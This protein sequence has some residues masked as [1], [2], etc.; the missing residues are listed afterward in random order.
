MRVEAG[1]RDTLKDFLAD[2]GIQTSI[3]YPTA[4]YLL[5]PYAE[6]WGHQAG[7]FS[8]ADQL[9]REILSLPNHPSLTEEMLSYVA[10]AVVNFFDTA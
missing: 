7:E 10:Q 5:P 4:L 8:H 9:T 2:Q 6:A 3:L 1:Q